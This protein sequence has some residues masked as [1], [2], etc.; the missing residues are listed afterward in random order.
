MNK[1]QQ[2]SNLV[3]HP[4][5]SNGAPSE[6][7]LR[8]MAALGWL[9]A[10]TSLFIVMYGTLAGIVFWL[11]G[12]VLFMDI[13]GYVVI[14]PILSVMLTIALVVSLSGFRLAIKASRDRTKFYKDVPQG[15]ILKL[16]TRG[17]ADDPLEWCVVVK[18]N[19]LMNQLCTEIRPVNAGDW[20]NGVYVVGGYVDF[21]K[22]STE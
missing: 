2:N 19:N 3:V 16:I 22:T 6:K 10:T 17:G 13:Y 9:I 21:R 7:T 5:P 18:G 1:V 12:P 4:Q 11:I 8:I 15:R 20:H 14:W